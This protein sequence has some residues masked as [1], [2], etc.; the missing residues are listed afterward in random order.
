MGARARARELST[1]ASK[2]VN[3]CNKMMRKQVTRNSTGAC[4]CSWLNARKK[5]WL[6]MEK[7]VFQVNATQAFC[8]AQKG[9]C[10]PAVVVDNNCSDYFPNRSR[11]IVAPCESLDTCLPKNTTAACSTIGNDV[12]Q[13]KET[14]KRAIKKWTK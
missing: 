6:P 14:F 12:K 3:K 1:K 13:L 4:S 2:V 10:L 11:H 8:D 7:D 5:W 9:R